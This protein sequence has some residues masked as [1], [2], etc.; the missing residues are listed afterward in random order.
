M[1]KI[2]KIASL[3]VMASAATATYATTVNNIADFKGIERYTGGSERYPSAPRALNYTQDGNTYLQLSADGKRIVKHETKTGKELETLMDLTHT[4]ETTLES[5]EGYVLSP[6]GSKILVYRNRRSIYRRSFDAEYYVYEIRSRI[7]KPL[8]TDHPRQRAALFSPNGR[9][10]AFVADNNIYLRKIDYWTEVAVTTDGAYNK[11][12][13]GVPDWTYEEEFSTA[14]S[15]TWAPDNQNLCFLRYDESE[16]PLYSFPMYEGACDAMPQYALYPGE[17]TYKYPVAGQ[18]NSIVTVHSYDVET[19]KVKEIKMPD[20]R[21]E[22]IPRITYA[23]SPDRLIVVT[24]NREQTRMEIYSAN[25]KSTVVKSLLVEEAPAWLSTATYEDIHYYPDGFMI[26]SSRSGYDHIYQYSYSGS[27]VKQITSG[28]FDV[29]NYYGYDQK[30]GVHYYQSTAHGPMNRTVSK[31]DRNGRVTDISPAEGTSSAT[32]SPDMAYYT[33]S[34][35]SVTTPPTYTLNASANDKVIKTLEDNAEYGKRWAN[36]PVKEFFTCESEGYKLN[37]WMLKPKDFNASKKYPVIMF[38]YSGPGSQQVLNSWGINWANYYTQRGFIIMCVDGRGTGGRGREFMTCVYKNLGHYES[39]DQVNAARY[40]A[41]LPYVDAKRIGIHGWS[42]GGYETLMASSQP[43]APYAAAVAVAPV[44][45]W[46]YYDTVY[47]ER[48][49]LTPQ[50]NPDGYVASAPVNRTADVKCPLLVMTGTA[51]DNVHF[52][53]TVQYV[54]N[55]QM[56]G[57]W[58]DLLIFPNMNHFIN[59][60]QDQTVVYARMLDYFE[61]NMR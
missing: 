31:I 52:L 8:S 26:T 41:T 4:R 16:V 43:N 56:A 58:C 20:T 23:F 25:P 34:Y 33:M 47:A 24:L 53:N 39:I 22:Y 17:F 44:T 54:S 10:I 60:C 21:T 28:D 30:R 57:G 37:G 1:N 19:R 40:A 51:D 6:D 48:Y 7:L 18:K 45:D 32:F 38:Q 5:I 49:M 46:R 2:S 13:N 36:E 15:M 9:M 3:A 14:S 61:K 50:Q 27:L 29:T 35:S 59:G 11:V 42:F 12:V 55:L